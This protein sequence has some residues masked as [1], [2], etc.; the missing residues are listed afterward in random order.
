MAD[1]DWGT[2]DLS[3]DSAVNLPRLNH[4]LQQL[5]ADEHQLHSMLWVQGDTLVLEEYYNDYALD[6]LQ[7]MRSAT[8]SIRSLLLGIALDQG[9]IEDVEDPFL[10]YLPGHEVQK[11]IDPRKQQIRIVDLMTMS[12]GLDCNDWDRRSKGQEDKAYRKPADQWVQLALDLPQIND[13]GDTAMYCSLGAILLARVIEESSGLTID[14]VAERF[15]FAPMGITHY[16]WGHTSS[17][18]EIP[19]AAK[20]LYMRPRDMAK[21][22]WMVMHDGV[23][24]G[25]RIVS[26]DWIKEST[27]AHVRLTGLEYGYFW[28]RIPLKVGESERY[29]QSIL[30]TGN[31]G[32]Y[33]IMIPEIDA[34]FVF[35]G[36]AYNSEK[37]KV[38]FVLLQ[39]LLIPMAQACVE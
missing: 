9:W 32:Q 30:A 39:R 16:R 8:K 18:R 37:D 6:S 19:T 10:K 3:V 23:W 17:Q 29:V 24:Q 15:L 13:P 1:L 38:P 36:G 35:T 22:G 12:S 21:I 11:N 33:I 27:T 2:R 7:D 5:D 4:L 28:W 20:R 25:Q 14:Q 34:L 31:G 26:E